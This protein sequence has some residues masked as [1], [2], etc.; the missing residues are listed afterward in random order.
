MTNS[1]LIQWRD[2]KLDLRA[3]AVMGIINLTPDSFY[4][5]GRFNEEN[6]AI[7]QAIKMVDAGAAIIDLGAVSTRP[8]APEVTA[9]EEWSRLA[10]ILQQL[11]KLLP[12]T[13]LS[14]DTFRAHIAAK[15]VESGADMINDISGGQMDENMFS[16][17]TRL[18]VPY[19]LMHSKGT[20]QT[21]QQNPVYDDVVAEVF[22][23]F[24]Q[25]LRKIWETDA[26]IPVI[27]DP[28]FGFGKTLEHNYQLL[29][30]LSGFKKLGCPILVGLSRK[31]MINKVLETKPEDALNGSTVLNTIGLLHGANILRVHDVVQAC[32]VIKLVNFYLKMR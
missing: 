26:D 19:I 14:V 9:D 1:G 20:P 17:I 29:K 3:P 10:P 28:G 4:D 30:S 31:S 27:L 21:M 7:N 2:K 6:N 32:E 23:F 8:F 25:N 15:A 18:Q 22:E 24:E 11:R 16:E 5:G 12:E 13:I